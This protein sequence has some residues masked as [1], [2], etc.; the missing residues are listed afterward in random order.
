MSAATGSIGGALVVLLLV[1][2]ESEPLG[3]AVLDKALGVLLLLCLLLEL[4]ADEIVLLNLPAREFL[5]FLSSLHLLETLL[6][7]LVHDA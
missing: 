6:H 2:L 7:H 4:L 5:G 1:L 3:H